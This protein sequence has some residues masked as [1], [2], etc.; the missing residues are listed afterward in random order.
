MKGRLRAGVLASALLIA[1]QGESG[2]AFPIRTPHSSPLRTDTRVIGLVGTL[3]GADAWRGEHAFE[4]ADLAVHE[5]NRR[6]VE[7]RPEYELVALDDRGDAA[8]ATELVEQLSASERTVGIVYAGPLEGLPPAE[9]ALTEAGIPAILCYG[10]LYS[11]RLLKPHLFQASPPLVWQARAIASYLLGDRGYARIALVALRSL[12]GQTAARSLRAAVADAGGAPPIVRFYREDIA[13][14]LRS[15][16]K[17]R[18]QGVVIHG[19]P[20]ALSDALTALR[21]A[22]AAYSTTAAARRARPWRPQVVGFD[23]ALAPRDVKLPAGTVAVDTYARGAHYLPIPSLSRFRRAFTAWWDA[24]PFGWELRAYDAARAI[25]WAAARTETGD[26]LAAT[27]ESV[28]ATRWGGLDVTFG[29]DD[30][31]FVEPTTVG[32]WVV[33]RR[34]IHVR[35]RSRIPESLP[36]VPL[37]RGFSIDGERTDVLPE[38]WRYLFVNPPPPDAQGP[39]ITKARFGVATRASDPVH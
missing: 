2:T 6:L 21:D 30:H 11:A 35:E 8:R 25:G 4:G 12:D 3:S 23:L 20:T 34:G 19:S 38:D 7:G 37:A 29:P 22:G 39:R 27:L 28:R 5:L 13:R 36:W 17:T 24:A 32:V 9:P 10:D 15:L 18:A 26:D 33:P 31:T 14:S 1:C 16:R